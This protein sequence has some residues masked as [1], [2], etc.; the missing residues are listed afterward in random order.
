MVY[1]MGRYTFF[2]IFTKAISITHRHTHTHTPKSAE[3]GDLVSQ[4]PA[5]SKKTC[6][7]QSFYIFYFV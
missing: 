1:I 5:N 3:F 4:E 6:T 2:T 7:V